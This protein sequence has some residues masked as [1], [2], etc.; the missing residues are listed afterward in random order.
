MYARLVM[1]KIGTGQRAFAESMAAQFLKTMQ[2]L[3][4]FKQA[5]YIGDETVGEYGVLSL[6]ESKEAAESAGAVLAPGFHQAL[7]G[8]VQEPPSIRVLE[9][10]EPVA[11]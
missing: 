8:K 6:W 9:V 4:G 2:E 1:F 10:F 3:S 7:Q 5:I 11:A